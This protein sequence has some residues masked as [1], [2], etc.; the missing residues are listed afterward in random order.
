MSKAAVITGLGYSLP[1]NIVTNA[2]LTATGLDTSD[3]WIQQRTGIRQRH[4]AG[5]ATRTSHLAHSAGRAALQSAGLPDCD[6]L[7]L[8]TTTPD[9]RC[10]ATA[11][12]VASHLDL[13]GVPA[14]DVSAVCSGFLYALTLGQSLVTS[15]QYTNP[16]IIG[17]ETYSRIIDPTDR[18][19]AV[20]FADGA[21][22]CTLRPGTSDEPGAILF[23]YLGSDGTGNGMICIP[24]GHPYFTM[25][26]RSVYARAIAEMTQA[27]RRALTAMRWDARSVGAFVA[28]QANARILNAVAQRVGI[29]DTSVI[30]TIGHHG[31]T[32]AASIPLAMSDPTSSRVA[33]GTR[34]LLTA[35]GGG[36]TWGSVA[37]TWPDARPT[38]HSPSRESAP[39]P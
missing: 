24:D 36:L 33:P 9:Q 19:T 25:K 11:P 20:I 2:S 10:P 5:A 29:P 17:A 30:L 21:A 38:H 7:I 22:A 4:I 39:T 34:T 8:A 35:F 18:N 13:T 16:L 37:I 28:H 32:A 3:E 23:S 1:S 12:A 26:G 6:C 14:F 31:N 15:G 27:S